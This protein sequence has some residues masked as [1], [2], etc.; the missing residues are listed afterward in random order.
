MNVGLP[1][2][3]SPRRAVLQLS[4]VSRSWEQ[5]LGALVPS[6]MSQQT[7]GR[8]TFL[9]APCPRQH[10]FTT[11]VWLRRQTTFQFFGEQLRFAASRLVS[12]GCLTRAP[13]SQSKGGSPSSLMLGTAQ[14]KGWGSPSTMMSLF[15]AHG[16]ATLV[17]SSKGEHGMTLKFIG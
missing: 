6:R 10:G 8:C 7:L 1:Q 5:V 4:M 13:P 2:L 14:S 17:Y 3:G 12:P 16:P 11:P 15:P 9:G